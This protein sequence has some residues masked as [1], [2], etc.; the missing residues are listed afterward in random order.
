MPGIIRAH[1]QV[2]KV[3]AQALWI[4]PTIGCRF[5]PAPKTAILW[6]CETAL[7]ERRGILLP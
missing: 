2:R 5:S 7:P 1:L 4:S 3:T 6:A